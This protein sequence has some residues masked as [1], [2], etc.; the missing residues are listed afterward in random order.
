MRVKEVQTETVPSARN[1]I[2]RAHLI[3]SQPSRSTAVDGL[4]RP[5]YASCVDSTRGA[6]S[7]KDIENYKLPRITEAVQRLERA[8]ARLETAAGHV[9]ATA[10]LLKKSE[11]AERKLAA[12]TT[13]H[14]A[15]REA[16]TRIA[17]RL[18]MAIGRL[19]KSIDQAGE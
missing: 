12:L 18:D 11:E 17:S 15:L 9:G 7:L 4:A 6:I 2:D 14:E 10:P 8:V 13:S 1:E 19:S 16:A 3:L 5:S